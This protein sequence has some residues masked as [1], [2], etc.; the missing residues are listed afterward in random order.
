MRPKHAL[1]KVGEP[2]A[3]R[4]S[5]CGGRAPV[6]SRHDNDDPLLWECADCGRYWLRRPDHLTVVRS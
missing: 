2:L 4:C 6:Q 1:A 3:P 5:H